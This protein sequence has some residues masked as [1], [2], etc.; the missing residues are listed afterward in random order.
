MTLSTDPHDGD[1]PEAPATPPMDD[2]RTIEAALHRAAASGGVALL[3]QALALLA[4]RIAIVSAFGAESAL[5][6]ALA[7]EIDPAVPVLFLQTGM[8]FPETL[9]YRHHLAAALGLRDVRDIE[10]RAQATAAADPDGTLW[11]FDPDSCCA[12]RKA[13][14]LSR[15]LTPFAAWANGRKRYQSQTRHALAF[16][17]RDGARIKINPLA[18][19]DAARIEAEMRRRALPRHPLVTQA[20]PSI[21][22]GPCTQPVAP[23]RDPRAGRWAGT[24]KTECGIHRP[25]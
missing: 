16:V 5:L 7:A 2:T 12:L 20:Y 14:P 19:W 3:R 17:E 6:L 18:D 15:A 1:M 23:G 10:P 9:E 25:P 24:T 8:H 13:A 22:C 4:G 11:Q 21:G